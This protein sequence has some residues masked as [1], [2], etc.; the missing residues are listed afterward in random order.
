MAHNHAP[1]GVAPT[2]VPIARW[3]TTAVVVIAVATMVGLVLLWPSG[4]DR[5]FSDDLGLGSQRFDATVTGTQL[6]TCAGATDIE[7]IRVDV[8]FD[9]G[10][11][12][13]GS[14]ELTV[15]GTSPDISV[16]DGVVLFDD[17]RGGYVFADFQ[18]TT[19]LVVLTVLFIGAVLLLGR[20]RGLGALAGLIA[21]IGVLTVFL[22]PAI[23]QGSSPLAVSLVAASVVAFTALYLA[24]GPSVRT[25]V[26]LLGTLASLLITALLALVFVAAS[27]ITGLA[28]ETVLALQTLVGQFD[29]RGLLLAGII[30]GSLGVLDDV[31]VTQVSAVW[32]LRRARPAAS[33]RTLYRAALRIGRDHISSTVNTLVL[34]YAGA[35]LP[36]LLLFTQAGRSVGDLATSE[37]VAIEIIRALVGSIGLIISVPL[38]TGLA[39]L[40]ATAPTRPRAASR[41]NPTDEHT[42]S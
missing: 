4:S 3:I 7:C 24:H 17:G 19:P 10:D 42:D 39:V 41:L 34:A 9:D 8:N 30:I 20:L 29:V 6:V 31:T 35:S 2:P 12:P 40:V 5:G 15:G 23:N 27:S 11:R 38:T 18:R 26:A 37:I 16:G 13:P 28:D 36:L 21:S 33:P 22:L 1:S 14:F 25:S 32:E